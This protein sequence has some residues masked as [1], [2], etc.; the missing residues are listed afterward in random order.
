MFEASQRQWGCQRDPALDD[1]GVATHARLA[2]T[3]MINEA[4]TGTGG[5]GAKL[6]V[7]RRRRVDLLSGMKI[8]RYVS[9]TENRATCPCYFVEQQWAGGQGIRV[10]L[11]GAA[12]NIFHDTK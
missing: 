12:F 11:A 8:T 3:T 4:P 7:H 10:V 9:V 5:D 6:I 1:T 2:P